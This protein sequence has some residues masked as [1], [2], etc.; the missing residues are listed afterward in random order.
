MEFIESACRRL[1][2][3]CF[4][5]GK[6]QFNGVEIGT[7]GWQ[8]ADAHPLSR[9]QLTD[10]LDFVGGKVVED[11]RIAGTQLRTEHPLQINSEDLGIDGSLD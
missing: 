6:S 11:D 8:V 2:Q 10:V 3:M 4:E 5:F 1:A 7:V 9:E